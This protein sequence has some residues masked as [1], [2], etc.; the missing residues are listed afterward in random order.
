MV[1]S[2]GSYEV[3]G[4]SKNEEYLSIVLLT[5]IPSKMHYNPIFYVFIKVKQCQQ[6]TTIFNN[7]NDDSIHIV[8]LAINP[9]FCHLYFAKADFHW[10]IS[11]Q[12]NVVEP[13]TN[14][15]I[16]LVHLFF[17]ILVVYI[18]NHIF[19]RKSKVCIHKHRFWYF[20]RGCKIIVF[21]IGNVH[22][23][24]LPFNMVF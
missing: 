17:F 24:W 13:H 11:L 10:P 7:W 4:L 12:I 1:S 23:I 15:G 19:L 22:L 20:V 18:L 16:P 5:S 3:I 14:I 9:F 21:Y 2:S 6:S 8:D